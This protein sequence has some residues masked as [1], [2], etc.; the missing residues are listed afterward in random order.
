MILLKFLV[1]LYVVMAVAAF[2]FSERLI[3][4][5]P[6]P[7]Y[8]NDPDLLMIPGPRDGPIVALYLV[9]PG[10]RHTILYSHGNA[11]DLGHIRPVLELLHGLG[12]S[13]LAYDY[14]GYGLSPGRP[15]EAGAY[16]AIDAAYDYLTRKKMLDPAGI[17]LYGRSVGSGPATDLA[18]R[19]RVGG[20]IVE[21][22]FT[23]A[24]RVVTR[25]PIFP[26]DR[27][28]N[29]AKVEKIEAPI[30]VIHGDRDEVVPFT[31]GRQI[32]AKAREPKF[33]FQA[34]AAR[35]NDLISVSGPAY[36]RAVLDF[37]A[38]I[39]QDTDKNAS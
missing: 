39:G 5:P 26:F 16:A 2:F 36:E 29:I 28:R 10:S 27:F 14:P 13:V 38:H 23:T 37:A 34:K 22:G 32:M 3:F 19:R 25:I 8:G 12:F 11:E 6:R 18:S 33:F 24:F 4:V 31:H 35:H 7:S 30:L 17:I 1:V 15:S 20:L 9:N 21:G